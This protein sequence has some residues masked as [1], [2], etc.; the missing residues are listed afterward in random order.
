MPMLIF[1]YEL[2]FMP[3]RPHSAANNQCQSAW[4]PTILFF[5]SFWSVWYH[6][7]LSP[8]SYIDLHVLL[9]SSVALG[10]NLW[11][12]LEAGLTLINRDSAWLGAV[13]LVWLYKWHLMHFSPAVYLQTSFQRMFSIKHAA[14]ESSLG[15]ILGNH[16]SLKKMVMVCWINSQLMFVLR[17][18]LSK[19]LREHCISLTGEFANTC[20]DWQEQHSYTYA[21]LGENTFKA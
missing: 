18:I 6:D 11:Q 17:E 12:C 21:V 7:Y 2:L 19:F 9:S 5:F 14:Y 15:F 1:K 10:T 3:Y 8:S 16:S 4:N 20:W 13:I